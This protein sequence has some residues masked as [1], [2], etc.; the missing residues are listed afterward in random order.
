MRSIA[1][2]GSERGPAQKAGLFPTVICYPVGLAKEG[3]CDT[4]QSQTCSSLLHVTYGAEACNEV[5]HA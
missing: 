1:W 2:V 4:C 5:K 3:S